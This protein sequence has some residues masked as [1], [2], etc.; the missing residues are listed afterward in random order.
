MKKKWLRATELSYRLNKLSMLDCQ[1]LKTGSHLFITI[2]GK[3]G[4]KCA[5]FDANFKQECRFLALEIT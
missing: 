1:S 2:L 3:A 4:K 5:E